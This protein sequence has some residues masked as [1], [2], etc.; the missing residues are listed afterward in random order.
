[1]GDYGKSGPFT[2]PAKFDAILE[3]FYDANF[4]KSNRA[5]FEQYIVSKVN[6]VTCEEFEGL[7]DALKQ[8]YVK[9]IGQKHT[10][11]IS[12]QQIVL[13]KNQS[14]VNFVFYCGANY[15]DMSNP[16]R[17]IIDK[18]DPFDDKLHKDTG[19]LA[20]MKDSLLQCDPK[21]KT[22]IIFGG[23]LLGEE[24][25]IKNLKNA[26]IV[27]GKLLYYGLNKRKEQLRTDIKTYLRLADSLNLNVELYMMRGAQEHYILKNLGRD[28]MQE[29]L[30]EMSE[31]DDRILYLT[32]GVS[33]AVNVISEQNDGSKLY[34]VVGFQTNMKNRTQTAKSEDLSAIRYNGT[35]PADVT[36]V[37][38]GNLPGK[39]SHNIFHVSGQGLYARTSRGKKPPYSS[40]DYNVFSVYPE[41]NHC[42]TILEGGANMYPQDLTLQQK[43]FESELLK[44]KLADLCLLHIKQKLNYNERG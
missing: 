5:L 10:D 43:K 2:S 37:C 7:S 32:E 16:Q 1:M 40:S 19:K 18:V 13:N 35:I 6:L 27:D 23:D 25:Q 3:K 11:A 24:W 4:L 39:M 22:C 36:F 30:E 28:I 21:G 15:Y 20:S 17:G 41:A 14:C 31:K 9:A 33:L 34:N 26:S 44:T 8:D 12:A 38:N 29:I 42:L